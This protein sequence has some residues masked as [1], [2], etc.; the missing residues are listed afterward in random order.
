[1]VVAQ[2]YPNTAKFDAE[3]DKKFG[4][5]VSAGAWIYWSSGCRRETAPY[6]VQICLCEESDDPDHKKQRLR[7][8][9]QYTGLLLEREIERFE[10]LKR[11]LEFRAK[12]AVETA[13][14]NVPAPPP[15]EDE[16]KKLRA[17]KKEVD[18]LDR[19]C[20]ELERR[21]ETKPER[22]DIEKRLAGRMRAE[23]IL[24]EVRGIEI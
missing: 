23:K 21:L 16:V 9:L 20:Q 7:G 24:D 8:Q 3:H 1:M 4:Q 11:E 19:R 15:S 12:E 6:G 14:R 22:P 18:R 5:P 13:N 17:L 10:S 2:K